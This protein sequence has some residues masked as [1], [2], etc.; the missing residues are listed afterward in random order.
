MLIRDERPEDAEPIHALTWAAFAPMAFSDDTE[1]DAVRALRAAGD[2]TLSLVAEADG[3][4]VG[5][6]AFSPVSIE[7]RHDGWF[8]LGPISV[9]RDRQRQGV[10]TWLMREGL[11]RLRARAAAG[12]VL[13]GNPAIYAKVGFE[14]D[15][16]LRYR[17]LDARLV[18]RV[19]FRGPSPSGTVTFAP[20]LDG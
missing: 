3:E 16:R 13:I 5:H 17:D 14:S 18:Q 10:G 15:G 6:V 11:E 2:L 20:G 7:G 1:A 12:C 4:I 19:V 8:G 9:R